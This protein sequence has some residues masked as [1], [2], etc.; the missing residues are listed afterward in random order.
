VT[1]QWENTS[2]RDKEAKKE[3]AWKLE[4]VVL[5]FP[6]LLLFVENPNKPTRGATDPGR[7][8]GKGR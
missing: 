1:A 6:H 4:K 8:V 3:G 5:P 7:K 2:N